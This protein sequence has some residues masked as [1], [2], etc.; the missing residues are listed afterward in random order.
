MEFCKE[1]DSIMFI[2]CKYE[3][4][5]EGDDEEIETKTTA[6]SLKKKAKFREQYQ[7]LDGKMTYKFY[8]V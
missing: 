4:L 2:K 8:K 3:T 1:C 5:E 6:I 7:L